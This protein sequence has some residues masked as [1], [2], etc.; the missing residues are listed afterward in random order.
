M[1]VLILGASGFIA[2]NF[3]DYLKEH[4]N[5]KIFNA[6]SKINSNYNF[7]YNLGDEPYYGI[8]FD[9]VLH[10]SYNFNCSDESTNVSRTIKTI[11]HFKKLGVTKQ[12]F[13]SSYSAHN[14]AESNYGKNKYQIE[15]IINS[16]KEDKSIKVIRP[17]LVIGDGGLYKKIYEWVKK[18]RILLLPYVKK[19]NIPFILISD[20]NYH[21]YNV[22]RKKISVKEVNI[23]YSEELPL[24]KIIKMQDNFNFIY[25]YLPII[26]F[27]I[28]FYLF[29]SVLNIN[30]P[31]SIN[32]LLGFVSNEKSPH[33]S[34]IN[35]LK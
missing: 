6:S 22:I 10:F 3:S 26:F 15:K 27:K 19:R 7:Y 28:I 5:Y 9:C 18:Y 21:I 2:S 4:T 12:I 33:K 20:L 30:I 29:S 32:N 1:K 14:M 25:F 17:G 24:E 35:Q 13:I 34:T 23:F 8:N 11:T 16:F 31:F